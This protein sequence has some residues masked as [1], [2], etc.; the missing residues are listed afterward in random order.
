M[1]HRATAQELRVELMAPDAKKR[2]HALHLLEREA[3]HGPECKATKELEELAARGVPFYSPEDPSYQE[4]V[5]R[6]ITLW[7]RVQQL[8]EHPMPLMHAAHQRASR[9]KAIAHQR[10][11]I[12]K[13]IRL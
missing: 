3:E 8:H 11:R 10:A 7:E 5:S 13:G 12:C 9:V 4:W 1:P 6:A 2:I